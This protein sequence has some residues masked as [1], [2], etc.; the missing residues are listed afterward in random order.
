M[1]PADIHKAG[2]SL[3]LTVRLLT[4]ECKSIVLCN[5]NKVSV[6]VLLHEYGYYSHELMPGMHSP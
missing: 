2:V 4:S 5:T 3:G 6:L 1:Q